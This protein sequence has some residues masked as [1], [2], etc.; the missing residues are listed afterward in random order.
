MGL[1]PK[2]SD[3]FSFRRYQDSEERTRESAIAT[4]SYSLH[5]D[6]CKRPLHM[7]M[8]MPSVERAVRSKHWNE[9]E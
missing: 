3:N 7:D 1:T 5:T 2:A 4:R 8:V 9:V 6:T